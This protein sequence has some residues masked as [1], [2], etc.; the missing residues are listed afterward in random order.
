MRVAAFILVALQTLG[1]PHTTA[2]AEDPPVQIDG[3]VVPPNAEPWAE[4]S[5]PDGTIFYYPVR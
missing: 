1:R 4:G 5:L 3:Q 2:T